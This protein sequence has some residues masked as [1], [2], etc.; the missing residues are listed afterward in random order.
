MNH[1]SLTFVIFF[2]GALT[3]LLSCWVAYVFWRRHQT[4]KGDGKKLAQAMYFQLVGEA[5]IGLGTLVFAT[6]AWQGHL[7]NVPVEVQ[8]GLR[9]IMFFATAITTAH[10]YHIVTK[11][12]Q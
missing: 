1:D 6:L 7:P 9:F 12:D 4:M 10:L 2:L 11:L 3:V 8:S 5:M